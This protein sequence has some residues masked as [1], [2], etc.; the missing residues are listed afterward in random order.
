MIIDFLGD[1]ITEGVGASTLL[2]G[3]VGDFA[4]ARDYEVRNYGLVGTRI[5]RQ[6]RPSA[7]TVMDYD[8]LLR[9]QVMDPTADFVFVFGGTNDYGSGD[10]P[11]GKWGERSPYTFYGA[12]TSLCEYLLLHFGKEKLCFILPLPRYQG[13]TGVGDGG[14]P[15]TGPN[16]Q[17][18][19]AIEKEV[20]GRFAI[21]FL[22]LTSIFH[23]PLT[24]NGDDLYQD[25]IH[26]NDAGHRL[27]CDALLAYLQ[28]RFQGG[29][30]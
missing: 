23:Q 29:S 7:F 21:P 12:F 14:K 18:Y 8:F 2:N 19:V 15:V 3:Y 16:L 24:P 22:D 27:I 13:D 20:L 30:L 10:A 25:G 1:S 26:P 17:A 6:R 4:R 9:A 11:L 5:A 28:K